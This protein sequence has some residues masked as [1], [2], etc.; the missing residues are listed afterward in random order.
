MVK[1]LA[2]P[3]RSASR[4]RILTHAEWMVETQTS[5]AA[6]GTSP[7]RRFFI[8]PAALLVNVMARMRDGLIR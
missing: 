1:L 7:R 5:P 6:R 4:R 8:S 2:K 3:I